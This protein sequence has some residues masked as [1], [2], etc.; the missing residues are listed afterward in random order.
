MTPPFTNYSPTVYISEGAGARDR[1]PT[2]FSSYVRERSLT[3][4]LGLSQARGSSSG[5]SHWQEGMLR[6]RRLRCS[7]LLN[8]PSSGR[9]VGANGRS[10]P[11]TSEWSDNR[12]VFRPAVSDWSGRVGLICGLKRGIL[13][14]QQRIVEVQF[15]GPISSI[16][17]WRPKS[18]RELP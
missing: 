14:S 17:D 1:S 8:V 9:E 15:R 3:R 4:R 11:V 18:S 6:L 13:R 12:C 5:L 7:T 2:C 16:P 10:G